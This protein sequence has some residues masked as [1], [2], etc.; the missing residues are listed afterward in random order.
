MG[1]PSISHI[2]STMADTTTTTTP[3][4]PAPTTPAATRTIREI[5]ALHDLLV[6]LGDGH[7]EPLFDAA[8]KPIVE[9]DGRQKIKRTPF[10]IGLKARY[11]ILK[12]RGQTEKVYKRVQKLRDDLITELSGGTGT[13]SPG[14]DADKIAQVQ[15]ELDTLL[16]TTETL[17]LHQIPL[18]DLHLDRNPLITDSIVL[19]LG[20]LVSEPVV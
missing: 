12:N 16:G 6:F 18:D 1:A 13:L 4:T 10:G 8:G 20:D 9:P 14:K 5:L 7:M 17:S 2:H 15:K 11:A 19:A 3:T